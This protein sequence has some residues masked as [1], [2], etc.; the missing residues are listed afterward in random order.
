MKKTALSLGLSLILATPLFA[1]NNHL[2][3][4]N[5]HIKN[6][7][8]PMQD[9]LTTARLTF[10]DL[11]NNSTHTVKVAV[12]SLLKKIGS[13]NTLALKVDNL[14]YDFGDGSAPMVIFKGSFG[15]DLTKII[16]QDKINE[17][18]PSAATYFETMIMEQLQADY[19]DAVTV[20]GVV[21]SLTKDRN[22][23]YTAMS[24]LLTIGTD[25]TKLP[26]DTNINQITFTNIVCSVSIDLKTGIKIDSFVTINPLF[27]RFERDEDGLKEYLDGLIH[28]DEEA[29][30]NIGNLFRE[31]DSYAIEVVEKSSLLSYNLAEKLFGFLAK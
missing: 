10:D 7:L 25:L 22:D 5:S 27:Y 21:T 23:N 19:G 31:L 30:E 13:Q 17:L 4:I 1:A 2:N 18:I 12:N 20:K 9:N 16:P 24:A 3:Q 15:L 26:A 14:S 29:F 8:A 28:N 6:T 11:E